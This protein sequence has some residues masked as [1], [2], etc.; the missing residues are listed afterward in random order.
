MRLSLEIRVEPVDRLLEVTAGL[1]F[2][3]FAPEEFHKYIVPS[4]ILTP[5]FNA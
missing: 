5:S 4:P 2:L 1:D 3:L